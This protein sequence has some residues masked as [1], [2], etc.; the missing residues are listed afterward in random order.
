MAHIVYTDARKLFT[1][2][3]PYPRWVLRS[4]KMTP[5]E[6]G[7]Y[8]WFLSHDEGYEVTKDRIFEAFPGLKE[9]TYRVVM[10]GLDSKGLVKR[11]Q[12]SRGRDSFARVE[13]VVHVPSPAEV[14]AW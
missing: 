4:G 8:L 5:P 13:Y 9:H 2:F 1:D 11:S 6:T 12:Q 14:E 7:F 10:K 3:T